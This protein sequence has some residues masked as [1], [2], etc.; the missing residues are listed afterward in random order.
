MKVACRA[1]AVFVVLSLAWAGPLAPFA[2]AQQPAAAAPAAPVAQPTAAPQMF[3]ED[4][5]PT[6][7][8]QSEMDMYDV[9][10][11][12]ATAFG[13]PVKA[14][15][16]LM[17]FAFGS[18][19]FAGTFGSR[20]D[21]AAAIINEGC[22]SRAHWIVRGSDIRPKPNTKSFELEQNRAEYEQR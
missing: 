5:K 17:G 22:G 20:P 15:I 9:G 2:V 16:C 21:A 12:F 10:A 3:Q 6:P 19:T 7:S 1:V 18:A 4:V 8:S 13:L 11:G 14:V